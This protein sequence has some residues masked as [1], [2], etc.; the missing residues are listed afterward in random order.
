MHLDDVHRNQAVYAQPLPAT[1]VGRP[2]FPNGSTLPPQLPEL[3]SQVK[4]RSLQPPQLPRQPIES[5]QTK[6]QQKPIHATAMKQKRRQKDLDDGWRSVSALDFRVYD[7]AEKQNPTKH[8]KTLY[9]QR[10]DFPQRCLLDRVLIDNYDLPRLLRWRMP[11]SLPVFTYA[12][13]RVSREKQHARLVLSWVSKTSN[14]FLWSQYE[15]YHR[16]CTSHEGTAALDAV[17]HAVV[18]ESSL[19]CVWFDGATVQRAS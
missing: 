6:K 14:A 12:A 2:G 9:K 16:E 7:A 8:S 15:E 5:R 19:G 11:G 3:P 1:V 13:V 4:V 10:F 17:Y 18:A